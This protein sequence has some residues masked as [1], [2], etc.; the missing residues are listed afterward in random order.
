MFRWRGADWHAFFENPGLVQFMHRMAG[1]GLFAL[2]G[3]VVWLGGANR[4]TG[5]A[6]RLYMAWLPM[7]VAQVGL[8]IITAV[9]SAAVH[10]AITHQIGA[11][12]LWVLIIRGRYLP[13]HPVAGSIRRGAA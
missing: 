5:H 4:R 7:L 13:D 1:Y 9:T 12:V 3:V 10:V 2:M 6:P 11:V 8:G